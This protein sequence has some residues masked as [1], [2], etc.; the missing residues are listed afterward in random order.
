MMIA[1]KATTNINIQ[2][3]DFDNHELKEEKLLIQE[4]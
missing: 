2:G 3:T 1:S 4:S